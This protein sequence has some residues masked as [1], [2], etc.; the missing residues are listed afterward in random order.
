MKKSRSNR[1]SPTSQ[2]N[3]FGML[4]LAVVGYSTSLAFAVSEP[5][6]PNTYNG[7]LAVNGLGTGSHWTAGSP[8]S[9]TG[10]G[11][12]AD[13]LFTLPADGPK[14]FARLVVNP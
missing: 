1:F 8:F 10:A 4:L 3:S 7:S 11:A 13:L 9:A 6:L 12:Y 5:G 14:K 2:S